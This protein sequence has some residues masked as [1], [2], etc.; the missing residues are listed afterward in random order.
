[1][2]NKK[3]VH[4]YH[5]SEEKNI[6]QYLID[7]GVPL[8]L[9]WLFFQFY[10]FGKI[11]P[12]EMVKTTG[13]LSISLLGLTLAVGPISRIF[14]A[15]DFLKAHRKV[16]GILSFLI[17]FAHVSLVFVYFY[18]FNIFKFIDTSNPKY[19]GI[20][21]GLI[22]LGILLLV[23]LTSNKR[24]L[25]NL[26]PKTWKAIQTTSYLALALAFL[27]FFLMEQVN[28]SLVIKRL[29]GQIT[30]WFS[31]IVLALRILILFL[32]PKKS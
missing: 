19:S 30:F 15:L 31:A 24:A 1:M 18:K 11:S 22:A 32:P 6:V 29:L 21:S 5:Y 25:E 13:L 28:G 26:S 17:A 3:S 9:F 2:S 23:T 4:P 20:L 8:L 16:W 10:N 14:P 7:F 27:H 12:S